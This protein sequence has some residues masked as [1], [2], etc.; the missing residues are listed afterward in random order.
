MNKI[1]QT[2]N[3]HARVSVLG[4]RV[5]RF[6]MSRQEVFPE[7]GPVRYGIYDVSEKPSS[8][9]YEKTGEDHVFS[10]PSFRFTFHA[11]DQI[12][13]LHGRN[14]ELLTE[15]ASPVI[16]PNKG[17][18]VRMSSPQEERFYGLG[19]VSR[20]AV[21]KRGT[22]ADIW[23]KNVKSYVP[24]P[25]LISNRHWAVFNNTTFRHGFDICKKQ[26]NVLDIWS[27]EG[28]VDLVFFTGSSYREVL[29]AYASVTGRTCLLPI[30]AYGLT[31]VCN[32]ENSARDMLEDGLNFRREDIPCDYIGLE[33]GW[34]QEYY[35]NTVNKEFHRERFYLPPWCL[36]EKG[37]ENTFFKALER[38]GFSL[39][40]WLC[41]DYDVSFEEERNAAMPRD[42]RRAEKSNAHFSPDDFEQDMNIG[43]EPRKMD[44]VTVEDEAWFHHL[45]KFV[46][47]GVRAFK[48]D[49]A[50]QVNEHP[51]RKWGNG[52]E[53]VEMHNLY[54]LLLNRQMSDGY[55]GHTGERPMVYSSGGYAGIQKYA[56]TWAGDTG[57]GEKPLVSML[58]H[59]MSG[60]TNTSCDMHVFTPAG[61]HFG[62]LQSWSQLNS[63]GYWRQPWFLDNK[64]KEMFRYYA[65]LRYSL[66]P[67]IYTAAAESY[68]NCTPIMRPLSFDHPDD[69][70]CDSILNEYMF[71]KWFL[72]VAFGNSVYLPEGEWIDYF[73]GERHPG[74]TH[75]EYTVPE[76]RGGGL[77][78]KAGAI[79]P[80]WHE[81]KH[82]EDSAPEDMIL[83]V[84]PK[85][86]SNF[87]LYEDDGFSMGYV[88]GESNRIKIICRKESGMI[89]LEIGY[90]C[91]EFLR[92]ARKNLTIMIHDD[93]GE[94]CI[95][96]K[97]ISHEYRQ[98]SMWVIPYPLV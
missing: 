13:S 8:A 17:Y 95:N 3:G 54:P 14:G 66:I 62:F 92:E 10:T 36:N 22:F 9:V 98:G 18:S 68:F 84:F 40:L 48:M 70:L 49:G 23:V 39:S 1:F 83:E 85:A 60:H 96:R 90:T 21:M 30:R 29:E 33:P 64:L 25:F 37:L 27:R 63:W 88:K 89:H 67:Y 32:M 69:L 91:K 50:W 6:Q 16:L 41:C 73:T 43:H 46:D 2:G 51:D 87:T 20:D 15:S 35:D 74:E 19:D 44:K 80:R 24:I 57:G 4:D 55:R 45:K 7:N 61:I 11:T 5:I 31:F 72:V 34:M 59:A 97:K 65:Q 79:I 38:M 47:Y 82:V 75:L 76:G 56:A 53:D 52:M 77:F 26:L 42:A 78:V 12:F 71:G 94:V 28:Y 93:A 86:E 81:T 58:N